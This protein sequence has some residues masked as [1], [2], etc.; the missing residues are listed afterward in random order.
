MTNELVFTL[1]RT[2]GTI[3]MFAYVWA[4][5]TIPCFVNIREGREM[6]DGISALLSAH[7]QDITT[8]VDH[9]RFAAAAIVAKWTFVRF[10]LPDSTNAPQFEVEMFCFGISVAAIWALLWTRSG[11]WLWF[12]V[13][14]TAIMIITPW[15]TDRVYLDDMVGSRYAVFAFAWLLWAIRGAFL[16]NPHEVARLSSSDASAQ[17]TSIQKVYSEYFLLSVAGIGFITTTFL[18]TT[19][20]LL[21]VIYQEHDW[22]TGAI[23]WPA[24]KSTA[25]LC[26]IFCT[27]VLLGI[28]SEFHRKRSDTFRS[29]SRIA[30]SQE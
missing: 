26:T 14:L 3:I 11:R 7:D 2:R 5:L 15:F 17:L 24:M 19:Q 4:L 18:V 27:A 30:A 1:M 20:T 28:T 12:L 16:F 10:D 22:F 8:T 13:G 6:Y 9:P 21:T 23:R 25:T 29:W